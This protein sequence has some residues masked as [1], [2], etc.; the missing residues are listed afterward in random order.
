MQLFHYTDKSGL[1][2]IKSEGCIRA[3]ESVNGP[4]VYLTD[5]SPDQDRSEIAKVLYRA[6]GPANHSKG[7]LDH[8]I[9]L[10]NVTASDVW[11]VRSHIYKAKTESVYLHDYDW[12]HG[13]NKSWGLTFLGALAL[14]A[15]GAAAIALYSASAD[16]DGPPAADEEREQSSNSTKNRG[17]EKHKKSFY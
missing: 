15:A 6:G 16:Q 9:C 17:D 10:K 1:D 14:F 5:L 13:E 3:S 12:D 2:G 8:Y 7:K 4:G 11:M